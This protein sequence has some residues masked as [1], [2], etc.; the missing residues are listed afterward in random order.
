M[1]SSDPLNWDIAKKDYLS[2]LQTKYPDG[3]SAP[4]VREYIDKIEMHDAEEKLKYKTRWGKEPSTE[5]ERL[6]AQ[7][8]QYELF[9]DR[10]TALEKYESMIQ[11]LG[12]GPEARAYVNLA[13]RQKAEIESA[14][15]G[16]LD[17]LK[18]VAEAMQNAEKLYREGKV[19][20]A[21]QIWK[22]I[23]SLYG[24]NRELRPQVR[25]ARARLADKED[26]EEESRAAEAPLNG[27]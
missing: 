20:E 22:S 27:V 14:G 6:Y 12:E 2:K 13:K 4:L 17:R 8:R 16:K 9:G 11:V 21:N 3:K 23:I 5:G 24:D 25:K 7:A 10:V 26:P 19:V 18:I 1:D 15:D